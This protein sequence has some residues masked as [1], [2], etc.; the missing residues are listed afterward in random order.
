MIYCEEFME[1]RKYLRKAVYWYRRK[2]VKKGKIKRKE[3]QGCKFL[4]IACGSFS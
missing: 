4:L 1:G 2:G 3:K